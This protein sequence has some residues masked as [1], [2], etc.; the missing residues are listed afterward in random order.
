MF[1][2]SGGAIAQKS[3]KQSIIAKST[4]ESEFVG[5]KLASNEG[6][7][8]R[9][10]LIDIPLGVKPTPYVSMH[11]DLEAAILVTKNKSYNG[12]N[13]RTRLRHDMIK[14]LLRDEII[15]IDYVKSEVNLVVFWLNPWVEN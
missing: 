12:E 8:L 7:W 10:F 15:F 5:L 3:A 9:N 14:H 13:R 2:L 6:E 11:C 1:T 4:M